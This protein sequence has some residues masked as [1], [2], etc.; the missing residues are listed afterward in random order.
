MSPAALPALPE[1]TPGV[2]I[3]PGVGDNVRITVVAR[4]GSVLMATAIRRDAL[5]EE[6]A[7][8]VRRFYERQTPRL[9]LL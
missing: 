7:R 8:D 1:L 2:H 9:E 5:D 4:S 6:F 3:E